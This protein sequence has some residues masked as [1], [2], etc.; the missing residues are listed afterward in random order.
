MFPVFKFGSLCCSMFMLQSCLGIGRQC[1]TSV[2]QYKT[3]LPLPFSRPICQPVDE[4][5]SNC[6]LS[7]C[8]LAVFPWIT[9]NHRV[10]RR[11]A[12]RCGRNSNALCAK[13][14]SRL[15]EQP[16]SLDG[17]GVDGCIYGMLY[18]AAGCI[19]VCCVSCFVVSVVISC[20]MC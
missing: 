1:T 13:P 16:E 2:I 12:Q 19:I 10:Q 3:P 15:T 20:R 17:G 4:Q 5:T 6:R 11:R 8:L 14:A 18:P 9:H 7:Q